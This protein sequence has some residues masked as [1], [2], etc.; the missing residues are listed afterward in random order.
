LEAL[1][2]FSGCSS[3]QEAMEEEWLGKVRDRCALKMQSS[4]FALDAHERG[5]LI[6]FRKLDQ[7]FAVLQIALLQF[8]Q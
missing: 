1:A 2:G 6:D 5:K 7:Y 3:D 8:D 4:S